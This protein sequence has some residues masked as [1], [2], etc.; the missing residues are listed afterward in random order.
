MIENT[1]GFSLIMTGKKRDQ[2]SGMESVSGDR[3]PQEVFKALRRNRNGVF[4]K[5]TYGKTVPAVSSFVNWSAGR[6]RLKW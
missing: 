1:N 3:Y 6:G 4:G 2:R 5:Q